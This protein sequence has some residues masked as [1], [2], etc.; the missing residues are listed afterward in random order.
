MAYD[1]FPQ[2]WQHLPCIYNKQTLRVL[3]PCQDRDENIGL[4]DAKNPFIISSTT[5]IISDKILESLAGGTKSKDTVRQLLASTLK[6][7]A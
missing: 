7:T 6:T 5:N 1:L 4:V 2:H 3:K